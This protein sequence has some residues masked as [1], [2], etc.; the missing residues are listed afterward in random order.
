MCVCVCVCFTRFG[1]VITDGKSRYPDATMEEADAAREQGITLAAIGV[2]VSFTQ[3][4]FTGVTVR[5]VL[6]AIV[7]A[8]PP[9]LFF[10]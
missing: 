3:I 9:S 1:I 8:A 7:L 6:I 4:V 10:E 2:T 5:I